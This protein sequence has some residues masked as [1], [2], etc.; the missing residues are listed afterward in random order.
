MGEVN[1]TKAYP[2]DIAIECSRVRACRWKGMESD[3]HEIPHKS[4]KFA[5]QKICPK[6]GCTSYYRREVAEDSMSAT[7]PAAEC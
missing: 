2:S 5:M 7:P 3:L 4:I 6:C 1:N